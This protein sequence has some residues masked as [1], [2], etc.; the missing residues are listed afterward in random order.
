MKLA[1][2][3]DPRIGVCV[4]VGHTRRMNVSPA[5]AI[6][7]CAPRLYDVHLKDVAI[8]DRPNNGIEIG[9]GLLD[10]PGILKALLEVKFAHHAGV[11][12]EKD[13]RDVLPGLSESVGHLRGVIR[14]L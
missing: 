5:D 3:F 9:R 7:A 12:F 13:P 11:E 2:H 10:I 6:R 1:E 4:D 14:C 8:L